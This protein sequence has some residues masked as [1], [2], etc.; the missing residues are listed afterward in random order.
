MLYTIP[1]EGHKDDVKLSWTKDTAG[2]SN[3]EPCKMDSEFP[4]RSRNGCGNFKNTPSDV[5]GMS[6]TGSYLQVIKHFEVQKISGIPRLT[7]S[8][9]G[10]TKCAV[11]LIVEEI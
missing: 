1:Q 9:S 6:V 4:T 8:I 11:A 3:S 2:G 10:S 5:Y 7:I